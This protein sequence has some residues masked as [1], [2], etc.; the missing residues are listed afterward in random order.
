MCGP[1]T[2]SLQSDKHGNVPESSFGHD[3]TAKM[4]HNLLHADE[5]KKEHVTQQDLVLF[6]KHC[7]HH[8]NALTHDRFA[9]HDQVKVLE[10]RI[11]MNVPLT[12]KEHSKISF[13]IF[14]R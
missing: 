10:P 12:S 13:M 14:A 9:P 4:D 1:P 8:L 3:H 11:A 7:L 5:R 2:S 6:H